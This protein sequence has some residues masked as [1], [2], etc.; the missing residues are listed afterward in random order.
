MLQ[1]ATAG[2]RVPQK[3]VTSLGQGPICEKNKG[4]IEEKL[5]CIATYDSTADVCVEVSMR[6]FSF[7]ITFRHRR[8]VRGCE[9][10]T[11]L[12]DTQLVCI[13]N[14]MCGRNAG[15]FQYWFTQTLLSEGEELKVKGRE[16]QENE[17]VIYRWEISIR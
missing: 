9:R 16:V 6:G 17:C 14:F 2:T 5:R 1:A 12:N 7:H 8:T 11:S 10:C 15:S 13:R 4:L 3:Q